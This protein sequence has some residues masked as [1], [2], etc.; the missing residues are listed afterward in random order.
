[1]GLQISIREAGDVTIL[2][3]QGRATIGAESDL[4]SDH[5][6]K[7][8]AN[9]VRKLLLNLAD[10]TQLD[11]SGISAIVGTHSYL[12]RQ[13]G[14]LKLLCPWGR[15]RAVL[16]VIRLPDVI[17]TFEDETQALASFRPLRYFAKP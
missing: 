16:R 10:I 15:V 8:V 2:D 13:G 17:P 1:V 11:S 12:G 5:L 9:G 6:Q 3:L 7:L 4:L 14:S